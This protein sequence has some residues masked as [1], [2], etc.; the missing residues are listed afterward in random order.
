MVFGKRPL[1]EEETSDLEKETGTL[2]LKSQIEDKIATLVFE[3]TEQCD[4][5][6]QET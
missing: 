4:T 5:S 3:L 2:N 6:E 1:P